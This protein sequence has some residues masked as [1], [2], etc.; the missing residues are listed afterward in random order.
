MKGRGEQRK[1]LPH[2]ARAVDDAGGA[3]DLVRSV[4]AHRGD[5]ADVRGRAGGNARVFAVTAAAVHPVRLV[6]DVPD[7]VRAA[8]EVQLPTRFERFFSFFSFFSIFVFVVV[9]VVQ[10]LVRV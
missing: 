3:D 10:I 7:R 9:V 5:G 2:A 8:A 4:A 1:T 6:R